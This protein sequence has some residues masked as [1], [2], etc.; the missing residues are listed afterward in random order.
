MLMLKVIRR[1]TAE[2]ASMSMA[3]RTDVTELTRRYWPGTIINNVSAASH[4]DALQY[5]RHSQNLVLDCQV[6]SMQVALSITT[7][8]VLHHQPEQL[9]RFAQI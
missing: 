8:T 2:F 9:Q 1:T 4:V 5:L 7:V 3:E 6:P